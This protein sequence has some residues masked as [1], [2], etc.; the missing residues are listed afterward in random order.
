[1]ICS[2]VG[3]AIVALCNPPVIRRVGVAILTTAGG[4]IAGL[5]AGISPANAGIRQG[6]GVSHAR[7]AWPSGLPLACALVL[8]AAAW[9]QGV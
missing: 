2:C 6:E 3:S 4:V 9:A 8:L 7:P 1:M 5:V